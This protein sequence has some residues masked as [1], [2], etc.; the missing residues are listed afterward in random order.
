MASSAAFFSSLLE[1]PLIAWTESPQIIVAVSLASDRTSI[2]FWQVAL[3]D[4]FFKALCYLTLAADPASC[5][6]FLF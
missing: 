3:F 2:F 5:Q 4:G 6:L 1:L